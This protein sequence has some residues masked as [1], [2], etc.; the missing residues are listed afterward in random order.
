[1]RRVSFTPS[2]TGKME[3]LIYEAGAD[4]DRRLDV[5][6]STIGK[7]RKGMVRDLDVKRGIRASIDIEL[8]GDFEGAMKVVAHEV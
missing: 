1:M 2:F 6:R 4:T 5:L 7:I 8:D 3:L